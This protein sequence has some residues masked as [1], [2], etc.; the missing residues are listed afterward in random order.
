MPSDTLNFT[1][2]VL[3]PKS[4]PATQLTCPAGDTVSPAGPLMS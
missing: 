2:S 1:V 3:P 4:S